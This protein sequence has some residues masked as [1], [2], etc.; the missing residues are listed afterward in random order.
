MTLSEYLTRARES[1]RLKTIV[2]SL[3]FLLGIA[4]VIIGTQKNNREI[5]GIVSTA[6]GALSGAS[7]GILIEQ[8]FRSDVGLLCKCLLSNLRFESRPEDSDVC[9]GRWHVYYASTK[10]GKRHWFHT[11]YD[12][13]ADTT[14]GALTGKFVII[15]KN[16]KKRFYSLEAGVRGGSLILFS[17]AINGAERIA[18]EI[19]INATATHVKN[20]CGLQILEGWDTHLLVSVSLF[21][22]EPILGITKQDLDEQTADQLEE[23][24]KSEFRT[25]G[26]EMHVPSL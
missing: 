17:K 1:E 26:M 9:S 11:T 7:L 18:A 8:L 21:S 6:G 13:A 4:A 22:R 15:G 20:F 19:V 23:L 2:M 12:L 14:T 3:L 25:Q 5:Y 10:N 24:W 16:N